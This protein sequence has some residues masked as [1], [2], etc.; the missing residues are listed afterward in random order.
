MYLFSFLELVYLEQGYF[1]QISS[2][3]YNKQLNVI[4]QLALVSQA[5]VTFGVTFWCRVALVVE[6][7]KTLY[8]IWSRALDSAPN[9]CSLLGYAI[10]LMGFKRL[11]IAYKVARPQPKLASQVH[12]CCSPPVYVLL[13]I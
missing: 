5:S 7:K 6:L 3:S 8:I 12:L 1:S 4:W 10:C 2:F 9:K 13:G 11:Q